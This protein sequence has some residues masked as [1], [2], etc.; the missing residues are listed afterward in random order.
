M[1]NKCTVNIKFA[2]LVPRYLHLN[3]YN[4]IFVGYIN[5]VTRIATFH[6]KGS[7]TELDSSSGTFPHM[8]FNS[9]ISCA[10]LRQGKKLNIYVE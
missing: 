8:C 9:E 1:D 6:L 3:N 7:I 10:I 5:T 2:I 4:F